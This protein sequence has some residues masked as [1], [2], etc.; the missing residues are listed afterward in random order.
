MPREIKREEGEVIDRLVIGEI[1][2]GVI[3]A[4]AVGDVVRGV[5]A[6]RLQP[7]QNLVLRIPRC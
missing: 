3:T 7:K 6:A 5:I 2:Q 4:V 1:A